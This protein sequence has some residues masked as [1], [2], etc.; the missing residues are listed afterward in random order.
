MNSV[1]STASQDQFL[2]SLAQ[3]GSQ[4]D[5]Q[6]TSASELQNRFLKLLVTQ[7]QNQDPLNPMDNAQ[8]TSQLAEISTVS[9]IDTLNSTL[10]GM[11]SSFLA[12]QSLQATALLGHSVLAPGNDLMLQNAEATAGVQLDQPADAVTVTVIGPDGRVVRT[13]HL[14]SEQ[15]GTQTFT[16]DGKTDAGGAAAD[17]T[18]MFRVSAVQGGK[19]VNAQTLGY[20]QVQSVTLGSNQIV[21]N[22]LGLGAVNLSDVKQVI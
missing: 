1:A 8:V 16:W 20:G 15:A 13:I 4:A 2:A 10:S 5:T 17:G 6:A 14:G 18:Y 22:T 3:S 19:P 9:G 12:A 11:A 7:M 21:L